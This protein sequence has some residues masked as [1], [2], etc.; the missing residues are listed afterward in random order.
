MSMKIE[1]TQIHFLSDVSAEVGFLGSCK[2]IGISKAIVMATWG[3]SDILK[4][5]QVVFM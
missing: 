1:E 3:G 5:I 2:I 4:D